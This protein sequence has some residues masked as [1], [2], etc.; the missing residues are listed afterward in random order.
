MS[1]PGA[2]GQRWIGLDVGASKLLGVVVGDSL[3]VNARRQTPTLRDEGPDAVVAR[4][5]ALCRDL[6]EETGAV[7][8]VG[9]GFAGLVDSAAG[10]VRSSIMLPGWNAV[11]LADR[12]SDALGLPC[13][14][15][16]DATAAGLGEFAAR[17]EPEGATFI[18]LTVGT[19]IGGAIILDG[20]PFGG[21][22]GLAGE[23]GN[24]SIDWRGEECWCGS[25][26]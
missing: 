26:G 7:A 24:M 15:E 10:V 12:L 18:L 5:E 4:C 1:E 21:R 25:R 9:V 11:P 14:V 17:G 19:G 23:I 16:N 3:R 13:T 2:A 20:R 6:L 22:S 8:G